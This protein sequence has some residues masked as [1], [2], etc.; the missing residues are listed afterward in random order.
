M[1]RSVEHILLRLLTPAFLLFLAGHLLASTL[2][3][4]AAPGQANSV[5]SSILFLEADH[6]LAKVTRPDKVE[7]R[8]PRVP[9]RRPARSKPRF[10]EIAAAYIAVLLQADEPRDQAAYAA[11]QVAV[12][13]LFTRARTRNPRDPPALPA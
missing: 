3:V 2:E 12:P 4:R 13:A 11:P 5:R 8:K 6:G 7:L 1:D 10:L 9:E